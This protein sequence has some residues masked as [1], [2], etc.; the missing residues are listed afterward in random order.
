MPSIGEE[1]EHLELSYN[2]LIQSLK[3][4]LENSWTVSY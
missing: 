4:I 1:V 3:A 2:A